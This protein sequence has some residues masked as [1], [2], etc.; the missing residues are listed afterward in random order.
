MTQIDIVF[1]QP[2]RLP[3]HGS[4]CYRALRAMQDGVRLTIWNA[5]TDYG[6]GALHQRMNDLK[7]M[8]WPIKREEVTRNGKRV[9]EFSLEAE[10]VAA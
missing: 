4:Q 2:V 9:A 6:I 10:R 5:M 1:A 7:D 3:K 8:G